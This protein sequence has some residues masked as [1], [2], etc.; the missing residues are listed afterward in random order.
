MHWWYSA[1]WGSH[2]RLPLDPIFSGGY[3][4]IIDGCIQSGAPLGRPRPGGRPP[5]GEST[6]PATHSRWL[7]HPCFKAGRRGRRPRSAGPLLTHHGRRTS[8]RIAPGVKLPLAL[9]TGRRTNTGTRNNSPTE[10]DFVGGDFDAALVEYR[11]KSPVFAP[12]AL[13]GTRF[14]LESRAVGRNFFAKSGT[15]HC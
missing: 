13:R 2:C 7:P 1:R 6:G 5:T 11:P 3:T 10:Y 9:V 14:G 8:T 4:S 15:G 12:A